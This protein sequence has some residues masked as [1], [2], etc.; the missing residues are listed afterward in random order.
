MVDLLEQY[1]GLIVALGGACGVA[2]GAWRWGVKPARAHFRRV[3]E[4]MSTLLGYPE[5]KDP[6][7]GRVIQPPT[8]P[9]AARVY[10]L[11]ATNRKMADA[12]ETIADNQRTLIALEKRFEDWVKDSEAR[13]LKG[14]AIVADYM[15]WRDGVDRK[16][17]DWVQEQDQL[18]ELVRENAEKEAP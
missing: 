4:G 12:L 14:E 6:G 18:A 2:A 13:R 1:L 17:R 10:D 16:L 8:P 15:R 9:L 7:S 3:D 11:E 5:V